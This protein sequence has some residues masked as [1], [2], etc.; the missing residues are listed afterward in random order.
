MKGSRGFSVASAAR[1]LVLAMGL[2]MGSPTVWAD[3][4]VL[5]PPAD[6]D[7]PFLEDNHSC[8]LAAAANMLAGAGYGH[9]STLQARAE[10]IYAELVGYYGTAQGGWPKTAIDWWLQ[11]RNSWPENPYDV[12]VA[13]GDPTDTW[14]DE[15]TPREIGNWLRGWNYVG[16]YIEARFL[17]PC[18]S[19][20][21]Q[22]R[23]NWFFPHEMPD[24][25]TVPGEPNI[26][27]DGGFLCVDSILHSITAWGDE[28]APPEL[29]DN[30]TQ[31]WVT[32]SDS[33]YGGDIQR[34]HY[35]RDETTWQWFLDYTSPLLSPLR[36]VIVLKPLDIVTDARDTQL[37]VGSYRIHQ[38][39]DKYAATDL[40]YTVGTDTSICSYRTAIDWPRPN[41]PSPP[42]IVE[43]Q[44]PPRDLSVS[45][46]LSEDS[47]PRCNWVTI[48]TEFVLSLWNSIRYTDVHWTYP[49]TGTQML[50]GF[51]WRILT[52]LCLR[53]SSRI[54]NVTGGYVIGSLDIIEIAA[55]AGEMP[56]PR[57]VGQYRFQHE[58][59]YSQEPEQHQFELTPLEVPS[60]SRA[61]FVANLRFGHS[62]GCL[63]NEALWR[64]S[65]WMTEY[66]TMYPFTVNEPIELQLDW[67]GRLPYPQGVRPLP[68][69]REQIPGDLNLDCVVDFKDLALM[70]DHW[71]ARGD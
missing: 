23:T 11:N 22:H 4:L 25:G 42:V 19:T 55:G 8:W 28:A 64:F 37:V 18:G 36:G 33:D 54:E 47:V 41:H 13:Y 71:L 68:T 1:T 12:C 69:C 60:A 58:Y 14:Q 66:P 49:A 62:Y 53:P 16:L 24:G 43:N 9:G 67:K 44:R 32:D 70:A 51:Q 34:Y 40:H 26:P 35:T 10:S 31:V 5:N 3:F 21:G 45:W 65:R 2:G 20:D 48:T 52:P 15:Y 56:S 59:L 50:P 61:Y 38:E 29:V 39:Y 27:T 17:R 46:D 7:K 30:P 57:L 63:G 6:A